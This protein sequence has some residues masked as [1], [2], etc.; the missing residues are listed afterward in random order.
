MPENLVVHT[1][2]K[3]ENLVT[4]LLGN[5][6][7]PSSAFAKETILVANS[8]IQRYL[9]LKIAKQLGI[10]SHVSLSYLGSF[11]WQC[12]QRIGETGNNAEQ[13]VLQKPSNARALSY[14]I[15]HQFN[16]LS[17]TDEIDAV[18]ENA[19][20]GLASS[21][22]QFALAKQVASLFLRYSEQRPQIIQRWQQAQHYAEHPHENWQ[23]QLFHALRLGQQLNFDNQ[24]F[25]DGCRELPVT[26]SEKIH[27]FGFHHLSP[28]QIA[29]L[30]AISNQT[31]VYFYL[32]NPSEDF[33]LD[34]MNPKQKAKQLTLFAE[35]TADSE[36][37]ID[38]NNATNYENP[39]LASLSKAG[40]YLF[41]ELIDFEP[42]NLD[43]AIPSHQADDAATSYLSAVQQAILNPLEPLTK[44]PLETRDHSFVIQN[45][46]SARREVEVLHDH[47]LD[48]LNGQGA[49][50]HD[51]IS[52]AD[53]IVMMPNLSDY[54]EHIH[55]VFGGASQSNANYQHIPYTML[56][57]RG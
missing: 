5:I 8:G 31:P 21:E 39:L 55:S 44:P 15:L 53:I 1:S 32:L 42:I 50:Q 28:N 29:A 27:L 25:I 34:F 19:L 24:A 57:G 37:E 4:L 30:R 9:E 7:T 2:Q 54:S 26:D 18:L 23:Y 56:R 51:S 36:P 17:S 10:C 38:S 11:L 20:T 3:T 16:T 41:S 6:S 12:Q 33:W 47:L 46:T 14:Q 49:G 35:S 45:T 43:K 13:K 52:A 48:L 22:Q 40:K